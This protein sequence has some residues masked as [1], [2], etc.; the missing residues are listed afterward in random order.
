MV[1]SEDTELVLSLQ[2]A[3]FSMIF[4]DLIINTTL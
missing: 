3:V 4:G 2:L 1:G